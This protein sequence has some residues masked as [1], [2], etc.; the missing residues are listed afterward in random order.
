M[1]SAFRPTDAP[2]ALYLEKIRD[3][4]AKYGILYAICALLQPDERDEFIVKIKEANP[5]TNS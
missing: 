5:K 2:S 1:T 4:V 3:S